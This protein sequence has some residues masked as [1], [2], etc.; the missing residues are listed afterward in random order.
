MTMGLFLGL[1]RQQA[2]CSLLAPTH[3]SVP[4]RLSLKY[5]RRE[6]KRAEWMM[7]SM[8]RENEMERV[9][10]E[11]E[12]KEA[13]LYVNG[14]RRVLPDGLAHFT[15]LEYLRGIIIF[16]LTFLLTLWFIILFAREIGEDWFLRMLLHAQLEKELA[17]IWVYTHKHLVRWDR[18]SL[19]FY[20][21]SFPF[22]G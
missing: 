6:R 1:N 7:G 13:I 8:L 15:L 11:S 12:L 3:N 16:W 18:F 4:T 19:R 9:E 22:N 14:V 2:S 20:L 10:G 17:L 5:T 21:T